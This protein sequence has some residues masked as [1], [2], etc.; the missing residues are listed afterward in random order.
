MGIDLSALPA[1]EIVE[2]VSFEAIVSA[3]KSDVILRYPE[4]EPVLALESEPMVKLIEVFAYRELIL[5]AR[6]NDAAK[7]VMLAYA[8]GS[9]L[10]HLA[11]LLGVA[12]LT[13]ETDDRLRARTQL[14]LEGYSTAGPILSYKYHA[15]ATSSEVRDIFVA[16]L[17]PGEVRVV[18]LAE[19]SDSAPIGKPSSALLE[20]VALRL[21]SDDI[22][23]LCDTVA[24]VAADVITYGV[25]AALVCLPGPDTSVVLQAARTACE[26]YVLKQFSLGCDVTIS[27]LHAA[28]HQP[29]VMRVDLTSPSSSIAVASDQ[30]AF[31]TGVVVEM[32]GVGV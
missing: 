29:G 14:S 16:S 30:A 10:E 19:P 32:N 23:P 27:G 5:R 4:A 26:Q 18:V 24:V 28:L 7:S 20:S 2:T 9:D 12:R 11:A 22:R 13:D 6:I 8:T 25:E 1:P 17:V 21:N 15:M 31:C 3:I